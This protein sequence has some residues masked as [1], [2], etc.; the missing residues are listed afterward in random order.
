MPSSASA[1][2]AA[3]IPAALPVGHL[4]ESSL[5]DAATMADDED[6]GEGD[7]FKDGEAEEAGQ[8]P[9]DQAKEKALKGTAPKGTVAV[10]KS[11]LADIQRTG[12]LTK[13]AVHKDAA[14]GSL[15]NFT[16]KIE[17][18]VRASEAQCVNRL[19]F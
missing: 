2:Y 19:L 12:S 10:D 5:A 11:S 1:S 13:K 17:T 7:G 4:F 14:Q 3:A 18:G 8:D 16:S 15:V 6:D 9:L